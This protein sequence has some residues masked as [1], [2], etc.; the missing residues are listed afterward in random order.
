MKRQPAQINYFFKGAYVELLNTIRS[1][2]QKLGENI[3]D[4]WDDVADNFMEF[5]EPFWSALVGI[6]AF[7]LDWEDLLTAAAAICRFG[8]YAGKLLCV[9]VITTSL[10][11]LFSALHIMILVPIMLVAYLC[12]TV[13]LCAD[14]IYC[15]I[16]KISSNCSNPNCQSHFALPVYHCPACGAYHDSLRPSKYGI[17]KRTCQCGEKLPTTFFN[18]RGR[19]DSHCPVCQTRVDDGGMHVDICIPVVGGASSGKTCFIS[20][21]ISSIDEISV[22]YGLQFQYS[23]TGSEDYWSNI[24]GM[25]LGQLPDKTHEM[26]LKYYRFY[27]TP[28]NTPVKNLI[29]L[30]DVGGEVYSDRET[31]GSQV[32]YRHAN[33][34]LFLIDPL[35]IDPYRNEISKSVDVAQY[36]YSHESIDAMLDTLVITLENM[37]CIGPSEKLPADIAVVFTKGDIPNLSQRIGSQAVSQYV[38]QHPNCTRSDAQNTLCAQF[39]S[40]YDEG[41]FLNTLRSK[42]RTVQFFVC[43]S[44]GHNSDGT[45][46]VSDG[47]ETP[48]LWLL[49]RSHGTINTYTNV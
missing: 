24:S 41:N 39:L 22:H 11:L 29:S 28:P 4:A 1:S 14:S 26:R 44:L 46:F 27:L 33:A 18:G 25:R 38:A 20:S 3:A 42:F 12:Y 45:P 9:L 32:G 2:F 10:C 23:P 21:A 6:V 16:K 36:G 8:F 48:V 35:S 7:E 30:C 40:E 19:L 47:V 43:S 49:D 13:L 5:W 15:S 37:H 34:F 17:W 31:L